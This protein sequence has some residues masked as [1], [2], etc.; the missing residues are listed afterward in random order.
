[1]NKESLKL[2]ASFLELEERED[3]RESNKGNIVKLNLDNIQDQAYIRCQFKRF[4]SNCKSSSMRI[5]SN[6]LNGYRI[7]LNNYNLSTMEG[8][9]KL[10]NSIDFTT[11]EILSDDELPAYIKFEF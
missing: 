11:K 7:D 10:L 3:W 5:L 8:R 1:M 4:L 6:R 9:N 2:I